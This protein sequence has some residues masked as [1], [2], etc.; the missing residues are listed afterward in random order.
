MAPA[1]SD[2]HPVSA[3]VSAVSV[4]SLIGGIAGLFSF[5]WLTLDRFFKDRPL[6]EFTSSDSKF[7]K[8]KQFSLLIHNPSARSIFIRRIWVSK[9]RP[10]IISKFED[11]SDITGNERSMRAYVIIGGQKDRNFDVRILDQTNKKRSW[12]F[13]FW[14]KAGF[15]Q[16]PIFLRRSTDDLVRIEHLTAP[17]HIREKEERRDRLEDEAL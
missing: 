6:I 14:N 16:I 7:G 10:F 1:P 3:L 15:P 11:D 12:V 4:V 5:L 2:T 9:P 13:V 17:G 8:T